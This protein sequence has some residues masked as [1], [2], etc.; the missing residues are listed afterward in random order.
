M[1]IEEI[2]ISSMDIDNEFA[3][4]IAK[5][6]SNNGKLSLVDCK[7]TKIEYQSF[8]VAFDDKHVIKLLN[9]V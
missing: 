7:M 1:Q 2:D 8:S 3:Q 6:I 4:L 9:T 5:S